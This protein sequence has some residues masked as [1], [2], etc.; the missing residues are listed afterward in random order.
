MTQP[1]RLAILASGR[2]RNLEAI[3]AAID[4]GDLNAQIV[5]V[6]SNRTRAP[7]LAFA[8]EK[9]IPADALQP[10]RY[11]DRASYDTALAER[12]TAVAPDWVV[13]AGYMRILTANFIDRFA[14]RLV[15]IHPSLLPAYKG[16]H[17][18]TRVLAAGERMH[19][20][21]V[22][23]V[24]DELDAG[25]VIRQGHIH[26]KPD[27]SAETLGD[28]VMACVERQLY[29]TALAELI[30]GTVDYRNNAIY[31]DGKPQQEP[32][33]ACYDTTSSSQHNA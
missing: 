14:G 6:F 12:V 31:R 17:T 8:R 10:K 32:P 33:N 11:A 16:L 4:L 20:A 18:H 24:T 21:S 30:N 28:R 15:N 22:H 25:P 7:A 3:Q 29:S 23:F 26:V 5:G 27:D 13:L 1:A 19:G 9:G 2:G